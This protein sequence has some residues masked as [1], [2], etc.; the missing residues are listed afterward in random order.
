MEIRGPDPAR[1]GGAARPG[2]L[3]FVVR[4]GV[5]GCRWVRS[6]CGRADTGRR[7]EQHCL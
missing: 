7:V 3:R 2:G 4:C 5:R 1:W 6:G